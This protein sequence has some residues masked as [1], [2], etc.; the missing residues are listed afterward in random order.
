MGADHTRQELAGICLWIS[1]VGRDCFGPPAVKANRMR[2]SC[3]FR[4][5]PVS[6]LGDSLL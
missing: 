5:E 2:D 1:K 3:Q 6:E 4:A